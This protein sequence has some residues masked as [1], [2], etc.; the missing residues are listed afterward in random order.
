MYPSIKFHLIKKSISYFKRNLPKNQQYSIDLCLKL[1]GFGMRS[2]LLIS[3]ERYFE[4]CEKGIE[5]K[6]PEI[7]GY[8]SDFILGLLAYYLF[9]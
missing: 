7:G 8:E 6:V 5:T 1:I 2:T 3:G 9:E 4:H